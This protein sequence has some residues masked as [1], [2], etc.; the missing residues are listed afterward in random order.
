MTVV[1]EGSPDAVDRGRGLGRA[2]HADADTGSLAAT[3]PASPLA[4]RADGTFRIVQFTDVHY[5]DGSER[6]LLTTALIGGVLDAEAPDLVILT[7]DV[8]GGRGCASPEAA[9]RQ[10]MEPIVARGLPWAA[11][12]GNHDDEGALSRLELLRVQQSIPGCLTERGP[13]GITGVGNYVLTILDA[14]RQAVAANLYLFDSNAY[15]D[16][17]IGGYGWIAHDQVAWYRSTAARLAAENGGGP[18]PA[19][20]FFHIPLPEYQEVWDTRVCRGSRLEEICC[21]RVNSGLFAAFLEA[22]DVVGTFAGHDHVNDFEG[23]LHGIRLC[24]G[25]GTG[26]DTYGRPGFARGARVIEI[27]NG[28]RGFRSWLRLDGGTRVN[29]LPVHQ[30]HP[31]GEERK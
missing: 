27:Q 3:T 5:H 4:C 28:L 9:W 13:E 23:E 31:K 16:E 10:V 11:V 22:G 8:T 15:A 17:A 25:R 26:F 30:P 6:D 20:A 14:G 21:P 19:L 2:R 18:P 7:G 29:D 24:Y 12:F 1:P